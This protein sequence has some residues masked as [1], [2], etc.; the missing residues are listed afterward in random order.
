MHS[1]DEV[2]IRR[3]LEG[4]SVKINEIP[5]LF[6]HSTKSLLKKPDHFAKEKDFSD[7]GSVKMDSYKS[8]LENDEID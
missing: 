5:E 2:S 6:R 7:D 1:D 4:S 3:G 8:F